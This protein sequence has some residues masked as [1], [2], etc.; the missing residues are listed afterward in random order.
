[1]ALSADDA[2]LYVAQMEYTGEKESMVMSLGGIQKQEHLG[3][4]WWIASINFL[5]YVITRTL[6]QVWSMKVGMISF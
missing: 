2:Q 6:S 5:S 4:N 1:V 3:L